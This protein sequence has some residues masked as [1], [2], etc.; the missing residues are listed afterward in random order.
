MF[1]KNSTQLSEIV[2]QEISEEIKKESRLE[3]LIGQYGSEVTAIIHATLE[4]LA[5]KAFNDFMGDR[6]GKKVIRVTDGQEVIDYR[7]GY[8][9]IK[10]VMAETVPLRDL[11]IP[12]NRAG[13]F[14]IGFLAKTRRRIGK[15]AFLVKELFLN[16]VGTRKIRRSFEK[17]GMKMSGLSRSVVSNI[18]KD[19]RAE[20]LVWINRKIEKDFIYLLIDGVY[21]KTRRKVSTNVGT[22]MVTGITE[23]GHKEVLHFTMG[24][25]SESNV[26][27][28]F[29]GL[30]CRGLDFSRVKLVTTDGSSGLI[31]SVRSNFGEKKIQRC[32]VHKTR[33]IVDKTPKALKDEVR[34]KLGRLFKQ[35][36]RLEAME[37]LKRFVAEYE[38]KIPEAVRCLLEDKEDLLRYFDFPENHRKTISNTNLIERVFK[39]VRRRTKVMETLDNEY[40]CYGILMGIVRE[41]NHRWEQKSH[42]RK[43]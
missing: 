2:N 26:D 30:A 33:N 28:V 16:G 25:E 29:Q 27:E 17:A 32:I 20:Y 36:S 11:R 12:R 6:V 18:A 39:E 43:S 9:T 37:Y 3:Q 10:Q 40:S 8:R 35:S 42:W 22:I 31:N 38:N 23:K 41:N 4:N 13:G 19:L 1:N 5:E 34:A 7:N 24:M 14:K 15:L 21:L